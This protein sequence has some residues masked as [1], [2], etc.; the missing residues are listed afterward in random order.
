MGENIDVINAAVVASVGVVCI[1]ETEVG[2][3]I[4]SWEGVVVHG[5]DELEGTS[6]VLWFHRAGDVEVGAQEHL[7]PLLLGLGD[8]GGGG[9]EGDV[10]PRE[11]SC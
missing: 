6:L 2:G 4:D 3:V 1:K 11:Q 8:P 10:W 7:K 5:G 9:R